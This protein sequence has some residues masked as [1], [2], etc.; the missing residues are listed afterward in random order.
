MIHM[1]LDVWPCG[2]VLVS[3]WEE[4]FHKKFKPRMGETNNGEMICHPKEVG[5]LEDVARL[6]TSHAKV[7]RLWRK[8]EHQGVLGC[9]SRCMKLLWARF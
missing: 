7:K 1:V 9:P 5:W 3:L 4:L 8:L 2:D 6:N